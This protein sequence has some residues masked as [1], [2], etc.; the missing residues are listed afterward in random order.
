MPKLTLTELEPRH[1]PAVV[2]DGGH[3]SNSGQQGTPFPGYD[4]GLNAAT[5]E[6]AEG[7]GLQWA[8]IAPS[9]GGGPRLLFGKVDRTQLPGG[10]YPVYGGFDRFA[11]E[12][13]F[14][15]GL[16]VALGDLTGDGIPDPVVA[17]ESGGGPRVQ[18]IDGATGAVLADF[19]AYDPGFLGGVSVAVEHGTIVTT[20]GAGG[21]PHVR[22]FSPSGEP[23]SAFFAGDPGSRV[24]T[25]V[26]T[27][28]V[29][30]FDG[31]PEVVT[32]SGRVLA[33]WTLSGHQISAFPV[34][35]GV[36]GEAT[37]A[38]GYFGSQFVPQPV[39]A[40]GLR[41]VAYDAH[42][43]FGGR[44]VRDFDGAGSYGRPVDLRVGTA[45]QL[46]GLARFRATGPFGVTPA[47]TPLLGGF[48]L[49]E[50]FAVPPG[51]SAIGPADASKVGT[52]A[53]FVTDGGVTYAL[54]NR[55]VVEAGGRA[56]GNTVMQPSGKYPGASVLGTVERVT[57]N[58]EGVDLTADAALVRLADQTRFDV[59]HQYARQQFDAERQ[60]YFPSGETLYVAFHGLG[61]AE[62]GRL[63]YNVSFW[64]VSL[65]L[66]TDT[67]VAV[68]VA[69]GAGRPHYV[70]Q[71]FAVSAGGG[72]PWIRPG[73]SGSLVVTTAGERVGLVFAGSAAGGIF[74]PIKTVLAA[75]GVA[76][77]FA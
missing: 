6:R 13:S 12:P 5:V 47:T 34:L 49:T 56:V 4:L 23:L 46:D 41:V 71:S 43:L 70:G 30:D 59:R 35:E 52:L 77:G 14:R 27:G 57:P 26:A 72:G 38:V 15:G 8:A 62:P 66:V 76:G 60:G 61:D 42:P 73:D 7:V 69:D 68:T 22:F 51:G 31:V 58:G 44:V 16:S 64:G 48:P 20:P 9:E 39:V 10:E 45:R 2:T 54:T 1:A 21:G 29:I 37:L 40:A 63:V 50:A 75:L 17:A 33:V 36:P 3:W 19:F 24:G 65:G 28:D 67:G 53:G 11:F 32:L 18:A 55:H 74:T 25:L